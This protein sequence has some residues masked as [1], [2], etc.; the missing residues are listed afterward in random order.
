[1]YDDEWQEKWEGNN[2]PSFGGLEEKGIDNKMGWWLQGFI[3]DKNGELRPQTYEETFYCMGCHTNL[4]STFDQVFSFSRKI[5]GKEGWG[6]IDL[7]SM[8]DVPNRGES[9]G[10][11]LTY[12]KRVGGGNEFRIENDIHARFYEN[13]ELNVTKVESA[14]NIYELIT[15]S[16]KNALIMNKAYRV[17][18]QSQDFLHGREGNPR[19][20]SNV[21]RDINQDTPVLPVEKVYKWDMRLDWSKN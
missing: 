21:H 20:V 1:M 17:L 19:P 15:P 11:I 4:G 16:R 7:K 18:V 10:E 6:Y 13:G 3:E 2:A 9:E 5:D 8:L 14:E 12:L